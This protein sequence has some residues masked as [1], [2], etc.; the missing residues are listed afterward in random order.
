MSLSHRVPYLVV[1][2]L[3]GLA[4]L[5]AGCSRDVAQGEDFPMSTGAL[6]PIDQAAPDQFATATFALG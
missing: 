3:L 6:P 1:G 4:V 5:L 2:L